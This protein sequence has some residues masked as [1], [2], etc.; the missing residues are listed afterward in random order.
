MKGHAHDEVFRADLLL[1]LFAN[2][3]QDKRIAGTNLR[4][5]FSLHVWYLYVVDAVMKNFPMVRI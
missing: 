2:E 4:S 1:H 5:S 3:L